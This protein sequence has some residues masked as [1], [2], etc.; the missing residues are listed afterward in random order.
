MKFE[1]EEEKNAKLLAERGIGFE[2]I[3]Q[4]IAD[5][6]LLSVTDHHN[7]GKYPNQKIL[8]VHFG[9]EVYVVPCVEKNNDVIFLKTIFPSRKARKLF[10]FEPHNQ[11][12]E[13]P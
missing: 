3:I 10:L 8:Y 2:E 5:G 1:F 4:A 12:E 7:L 11:Y 9:S 13:K 6:G